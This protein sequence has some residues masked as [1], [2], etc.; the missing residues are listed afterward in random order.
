MAGEGGKEGG[1]KKRV[2]A[3]LIAKQRGLEQS[4][5]VS[6]SCQ[7]YLGKKERIPT[8]T[9]PHPLWPEP[10]EW[11]GEA[12]EVTAQL[13]SYCHLAGANKNFL[14]IFHFQTTQRETVLALR[15]FGHTSP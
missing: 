6:A 1:V 11:T 4:R 7:S 15:L 8:A 13:T 14:C 12:K 9:C 3:C 10:R 2:S 5:C